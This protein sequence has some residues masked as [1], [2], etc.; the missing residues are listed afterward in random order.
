[1]SLSVLQLLEPSAT[2]SLVDGFDPAGAEVVGAA[3]GRG[4]GVEGQGHLR[5]GAALP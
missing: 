5:V 1:M 3:G 2:Q 4:Q